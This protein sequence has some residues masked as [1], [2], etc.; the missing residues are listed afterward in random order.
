[1][2]AL[3]LLSA[4]LTLCFA[5][6]IFGGAFRY[7]EEKRLD[8]TARTLALVYD[9]GGDAA[10]LGAAAGE[11]VRVLVQEQ[12][13]TIWYDSEAGTEEVLTMDADPVPLEDG[14]ILF[15]VGS[16]ERERGFW[17]FSLG[18][19]LALT[20][21]VVLLAVLFSKFLSRQLIRPVEEMAGQVQKGDWTPPY[22]ELAPLSDALRRQQEQ[23]E[24]NE[25]IRREFTA[26]VSH[27]LKTPLTSISGYAEMI[28]MELAK[29]EDVRGFAGKIRF[30]AGR[31]LSL[32]A[33][34][35]QLGELD[36]PADKRRFASVDLMEV[37]NTTAEYLSFAAE[38]MEIALSVR[39]ESR[40]VWGSQGLLEELAYNLCDNAIR[41][42]RPGGRVELFVGAEEGRPYLRV[43][44]DGIGI[45]DEHQGRIFERFYRVD[46]SH[47]KETGGTGLG[48]AIVKHI[49]L[50]HGAE[51]ALWSEAGRGTR[52]TV[53]F[54]PPDG[55]AQ[56][57][58]GDRRK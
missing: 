1:M 49:A 15:V 58:A 30:E 51:I 25:R 34:I 17:G 37:A 50:R 20:M 9:Q 54:A 5:A 40:T 28:E 7:Y 39:G 11:S 35:I 38:R 22:P 56:G 8:E 43:S 36:E 47:S 53:S 26:N 57:P 45:P 12:D 2:I 19:L 6:C 46:K 24:Q 27:E 21:V 42:N 18:L 32:I 10:L 14:R 31:L 16:R 44:D 33:D 13:G 55:G 52:V 48:L 41:Y 23:K 3:A 4:M 29:P